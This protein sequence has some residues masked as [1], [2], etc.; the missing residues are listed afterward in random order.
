MNKQA[1][2]YNLPYC[3]NKYTI[4]TQSRNKNKTKSIKKFTLPILI[5]TY[6]ASDPLEPASLLGLFP[7]FYKCPQQ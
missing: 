7:V 2:L 5:S 1:H 4:F 3:N 6:F